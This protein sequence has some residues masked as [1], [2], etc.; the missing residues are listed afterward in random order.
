[1]DKYC[2]PIRVINDEMKG[3][4]VKASE[5]EEHEIIAAAERTLGIEIDKLELAQAL[6]YD[7]RQ[8]EKGY[9]DGRR[10]RNG[11]ADW[12]YNTRYPNLMICQ[13]CGF[14]IKPD[15][16]LFITNNEAGTFYWLPASDM[17]LQ[18]C[19][20]CGAHMIGDDEK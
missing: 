13:K 3:V 6:A 10:D 19:P 12:I 20:K 16:P 4:L 14:G 1:M 2:S 8:Y 18:Y 15:T 17:H 11:K 7:R 9:A 5:T